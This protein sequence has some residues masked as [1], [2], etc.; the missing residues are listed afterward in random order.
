MSL[1]LPGHLVQLTLARALARAAHWFALTC[2]MAAAVS[3]AILSLNRSPELWITTV[4][5]VAMGALLV[6]F[7]RHRRIAFAVAFLAVGTLGVYVFTLTVLGVPDVFPASNMF[8]VALPKMALVMVG[9]AGSTALAG[10]LWSTAAFLLAEAAA[11]LAILGTAVPYRPDLFTLST[12]LVLV[13]VMVLAGIDRRASNAAQPAIHRAVQDGANRQLRDALDTRAIALLNDTTVAQLVALSL[14]E[15]GALSPGLRASLN[16]TLTTL[17]DTNWLTDIDAR[18][19]TAPKPT[20]TAQSTANH[21]WLS[22]AVYI[23]IERC[24]DRGLVVE[25][26]GDRDALARLDADSDR[27][28]G[29]ALQQCLV[30]VILHAGVASAEVAIESDLTTISLLI[31]DAGRGFTE[32]ESASDRLGLRQSVRRRIEQLGGSV[33]IWSRPGAGTSVRLT[34]P[35]AQKQTPNQTPNAASRRPT[36]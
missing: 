24:R 6:L 27:D 28:V 36:P 21:S 11:L 30:N 16:D 32:S 13:G 31:T 14:E 29:L 1:G 20:L 35:A 9:G 15:P 10:V 4:V 7:T 34:V 19:A 12:Y 8:L 22:S 2:L 5:V 23:T 33:L 18:S 26:T 17:H 3:V 25:V